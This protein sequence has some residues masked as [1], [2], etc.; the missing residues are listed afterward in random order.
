MFQTLETYLYCATINLL[1]KQNTSLYWVNKSQSS[2]SWNASV[3]QLKSIARLPFTNFI[4]M[5]REC[6]IEIILRLINRIESRYI[7]QKYFSTQPLTLKK[8]YI[9]NSMRDEF[10]L[11]SFRKWEKYTEQFLFENIKIYEI[12]NKKNIK[13]ALFR[14]YKF[15]S[16]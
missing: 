4:W 11:S 10:F 3:K 9:I 8:I 15:Y 16:N 13:F 6:G 7:T 14:V 2:F 1:D 5:G 12:K